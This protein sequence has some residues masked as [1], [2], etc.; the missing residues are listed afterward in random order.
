MIGTLANT[1]AVLVGGALGLFIKRGIKPELSDACMKAVGAV[2]TLIGLS[3]A[4]SVMLVIR[5]E[6]NTLTTQGA[7]LL[8]VSL[9]LGTVAGELVRLHDRVETLSDTIEKKL[10]LGDFSKGFVSASV[11]FCAGAM[12]IVGSI[13]DGLYGDPQVLFIKSAL[14]GIAALFLASAL[15]VGVLFSAAF[16]L[17][18]QGAL[19]LCAGLLEPVMTASMMNALTMSGFTIVMCIGLNMTGATNIKVTNMVFALP[20]AALLSLI[21][22]FG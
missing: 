22:W 13:N 7:L 10:K 6:D 17:V 19:T 9:V 18:Y 15:G 1:G 12:T 11:L 14:D 16:V 2:T 3:G 21:P 20:V 4:L 5:P 8:L